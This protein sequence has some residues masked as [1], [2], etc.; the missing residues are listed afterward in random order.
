MIVAP[1]N[2]VLQTPLYHASSAQVNYAIPLDV[3]SNFMIIG[4]GYVEMVHQ[5]KPLQNESQRRCIG[6]AQLGIGV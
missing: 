6:L 2:N 1:L 3:Q 5:S 4:S